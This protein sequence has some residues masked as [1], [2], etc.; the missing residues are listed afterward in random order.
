[1]ESLELEIKHPKYQSKLKRL[2][3]LK[4]AQMIQ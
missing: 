4:L 3:S 1:M 2:L